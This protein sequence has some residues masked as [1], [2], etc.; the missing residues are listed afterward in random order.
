LLS[1]SI[2]KSSKETA[3]SA[4]IEL[5]DADGAVRW[6]AT[7]TAVTVE[8]GWQAGAIRRFEGEVDTAAWSIDRSTGSVIS[9]TARSVDLRGQAKAPRDLHW[10]DKGLGD[11]L[12]DAAGKAGLSI[13]VHGDLAGRKLVYEA[14]DNESFIAFAER[15]AREHGAIFNV[16]GRRAVF[17][18]KNR[19]IGVTGKP[20]PTVT[21]AWGVN[22]ISASGIV[23]GK[24]RPRYAVKKGRWYDIQ[25]AKLIIEEVR[26]GED[27]EPED[28]LRFLEPDGEAARTRAGASKEDA[29]RDKG[30]GGVVIDGAPEAEPEGTLVLS[31]CR[32]GVDGA[33]TIE[34][35][36]DTLDRSGGYV[37]ELSLVNPTGSSGTDSR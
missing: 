13:E 15:L 7:G 2:S 33:Y 8:L 18:P 3:A 36:T 26:T 27:V 4:S 34:T 29:A 17:V 32:A 22:L 37:S 10:E 30:A 11:I 19:G 24:D 21:A 6:P 14:Q 12:K 9:I 35:V 20:L 28:V 16:M 25:K 5:D 23:P 1:A 31:G